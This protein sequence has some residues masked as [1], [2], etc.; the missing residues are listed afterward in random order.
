[1]SRDNPS[2]DIFPPEGTMISTK[3]DGRERM[4]IY[5]YINTW[6]GLYYQ[7]YE[8]LIDPIQVFIEGYFSSSGLIKRGFC[9][10]LVQYRPKCAFSYI[11]KEEGREQNFAR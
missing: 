5:Q 4:W 11:V 9:C 10:G 8:L 7:T 2:K 1:M 6:N 3:I